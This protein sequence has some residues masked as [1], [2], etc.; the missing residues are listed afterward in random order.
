MENMTRKKSNVSRRSFIQGLAVGGAGLATVNLVGAQTL[1]APT[2]EEKP[3]ELKIGMIGIGGQGRTLMMNCTKIP[4]IRIVAACDLWPR[5]KDW[6]GKALK[7]FKHNANTYVDYR[8]LLEKEKG[9]DAVLIATP[10]FL[11]EP[12]TT[13]A[14]EAGIHVYCEKEM[15]NTLEG[16]RKMVASQRKTGKLLQIGHQRRSNPRYL[17]ADKIINK[18]KYLGRVTH[19][20]GQW[21]R[22]K[23]P[24][25][26]WPKGTEID[27][28]VLEE[29]GYV[30]MEQFRNWRWFR[31]YGGGLMADLGSHQIDIFSWFLRANPKSVIAS[32]GVDYYDDKREF[33]DNVMSIY[34]YDTPQGVSRAFYQVLS[35]TSFDSYRE[36]FMGT[37]GTLILSEDPKVG[38]MFKEP[39]A[40]RLAWEEEAE[41]VDTMGAKA[42]ELKIGQSRQSKDQKTESMGGDAAKK[43]PHQWHLENFFNAIRDPEKVKLT[44]PPE[45]AY[46]T[47]VSVLKVEKAL[48]TNSKVTFSPDEFKV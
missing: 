34:E 48:E 45:V 1:A 28:K 20:N 10:D 8:E 13:A 6:A 14:L 2:P 47:A 25:E 27:Q 19:I 39:D 21:N 36:K 31:K 43:K 38:F 11:H 7:K 4:G 33:P 23:P 46:E 18:D 24:F 16:C 44:C 26:T 30:N 37:N 40:P 9:L 12:M 3:A 15:S 42:I 22:C 17:L 32:G 5:K 35:T 41:Q 29:F